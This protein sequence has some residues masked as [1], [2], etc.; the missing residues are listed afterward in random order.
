[1][2]T[3]FI[4]ALIAIIGLI[5]YNTQIKNKQLS[6]VDSAELAS[7]LNITSGNIANPTELMRNGVEIPLYVMCE[8]AGGTLYGGKCY[9]GKAKPIVVDENGTK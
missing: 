7:E 3:L 6:G 4:P 9:E 8:K 1:M 2:K 5:I